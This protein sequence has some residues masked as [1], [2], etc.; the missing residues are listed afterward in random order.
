MEVRIESLAYGGDGI[1]RPGGAVVFVPYTAPGDR[2][3]VEV[4]A[5]KK[6]YRRARL[7]E[8]TD[9]SPLRTAPRCPLFSRCGGCHLQH[10]AY[11]AQLRW[12]SAI[13]E[14]TL[15]RIGRID[16]PR[17]EPPV[18]AGHPFHYRRKARFHIEAGKWGFFA[19]GSHDVVDMESCPL[20]HPA[21]NSLL[22]TFRTVL[23]PLAPDS[24]LHTLE[25]ALAAD[26]A[27][28]AALVRM[29]GRNGQAVSDAV[30]C[31]PGLRGFEVWSAPRRRRGRGAQRGRRLERRG[32]LT[33]ESRV[34]G[35]ALRRPAGSFAQAGD[36]QNERLVGLA[37]AYAAL[38]GSEVLVDLYC[39]C[40]NFTL[41]LSAGASEA[42]G[43][44]RDGAAVRAAVKNAR[45]AGL[46]AVRFFR[47]D[48]LRWLRGEEGTKLLENRK[49]RVV[50]LDPPRT[51]CGVVAEAVAE[52][53]PER[54]VY[55]SCS[56]PTLARDAAILADRG[57]RL[58]RVRMVDMFPQ[59]Y[60][61]EA[62]AL[63][64][65]R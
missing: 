56:P 53:A 48:A 13:L 12:K 23:A 62:V 29:E 25:I 30:E 10:M 8:I 45:R 3:V 35:L 22:G 9:P 28:S 26:P 54:I 55:I 31:V 47:A 6:G 64:Q 59:T 43:I 21:L 15:R 50:L 65:R 20:L 17:P 38:T 19:P 63:F 57:Y 18:G 5:E 41:P 42:A 11:Q 34:G 49:P 39:G 52:L 32:E 36:E 27:V 60:H 51:G 14:E 4:T 2:A 46:S 7:I 1:A 61:I 44:E 24:G 58:E 33:L 37:A 16:C 40:G